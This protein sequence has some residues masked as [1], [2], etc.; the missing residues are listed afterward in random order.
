MTTQF[1]VEPSDFWAVCPLPEPAS[2]AP[3]LLKY[4]QVAS[5]YLPRWRNPDT[6]EF[7]QT[8]VVLFSYLS[9]SE[10]T[11][12]NT[13]PL[14][15]HF[16][17]SHVALGAWIQQASRLRVA[18]HPHSWSMAIPDVWVEQQGLGSKEYREGAGIQYLENVLEEVASWSV[19]HEPEQ[20]N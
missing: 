7:K 5:C 6:W 2:K 18:L 3:I 1:L 17:I 15:K 19:R 20:S 14:R 13:Q 10:S 8:W 12:L 4:V 16:H 9:H 11:G